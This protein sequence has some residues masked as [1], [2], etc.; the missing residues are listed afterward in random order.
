MAIDSI[1]SYADFEVFK[2]AFAASL[3]VHRLSLAFP[4]IEQFALADQL[5][6]S[7]KSI[8]ANFVEGFSRSKQSPAEFKRFVS[9]AISSADETQV[10]QEYAAALDYV[11][12]KLA[13]ELKNEYR[14]IAKMLYKLKAS[15]DLNYNKAA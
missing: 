9:M 15:I 2:K 5:R 8:C 3:I 1:K 10:W 6:R 14:A 11:D 13:E 7:T 12:T 4:K